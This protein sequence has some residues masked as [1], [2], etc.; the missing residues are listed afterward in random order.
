MIR[1]QGLNKNIQDKEILKD[2]NV[3]INKGRLTSMIGP[4][5]AGKSTLLAAITRL[6]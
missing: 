2:I 3:D 1:V 6:M 5:G 4:N